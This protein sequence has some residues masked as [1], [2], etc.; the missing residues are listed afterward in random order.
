MANKKEKTETIIDTPQKVEM[1]FDDKKTYEITMLKSSGFVRVD[2]D[3]KVSGS[4]A[5]V[6]INKGFATLKTI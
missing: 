4:V 6:L 2:T 3:K 1:I 5:N